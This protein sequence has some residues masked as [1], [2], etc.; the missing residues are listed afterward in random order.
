MSEASE[1]SGDRVTDKL[2]STLNIPH[3]EIVI[4]QGKYR[5][6]CIALVD[7]GSQVTLINWDTWCRML[8][9]VLK[10]LVIRNPTS[11]QLTAAN[12]QE[13]K[14]E[15][16]CSLPITVGKV[17]T[18]LKCHIVKNLNKTILLG[19]DFLRYSKTLVDFIRMLL[20]IRKSVVLTK[21]FALFILTAPLQPN[22]VSSSLL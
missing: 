2:M 13:V 10:Q 16:Q 21:I 22:A 12:G 4:Q 5:L 18:R 15:G 20:T 9:E 3:C 8:K 7:S 17:T 1:K 11:V 6:Y 14:H 19:A